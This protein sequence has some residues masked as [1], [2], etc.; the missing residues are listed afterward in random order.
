[1][2]FAA[3]LLALGCASR[4]NAEPLHAKIDRLVAAGHPG[5]DQ[6]AAPLADD[7]EFHRRAALDLTGTIPSAAEVRLFLADTAPDKRTKL[8]DRLLSGPGYARR[9][10][11]AFDVTLMERRRDVKVPRADWEAYLRASFA[12]NKPYDQLAREI[13]SADGVDPKGRAPAKFYLDRDFEPNLV[14][15]DVGRVFLGRNLACAQ[16][17]DHPIVADS[18]Q[19][20]YY[21]LF[22]FL[23][24][25]YLFPTAADAKAVVAEKADGDVTF[26][27]VFDKAKGQKST[28][29]GCRGWR[30]W[31][32]RRSRRGRSTRSRRPR[33]SARS[34]RTAGGSSWRRR[35]P[36]RRTP[37]SPG[38]RP[39]GCGRT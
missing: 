12:S 31:P 25:S 37:P 2:R 39:T 38:R 15:R 27:S 9:M 28:V 3:L 16:C 14:T 6:Y 10:A 33:T 29:P 8:I 5:Y 17:H 20:D 7:A 32:S 22:A 4:L 1:M 26:V 19:A 30:P 13:L 34:R 18:K 23:S 24:R 36:P 11:Q 21:G 35:S